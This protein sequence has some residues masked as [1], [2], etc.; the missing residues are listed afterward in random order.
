MSEGLMTMEEAA[1]Y[2][3]LTPRHVKELWARRRLTGVKMGRKVRFRRCDLD[4][5]AD[6]CLVRATR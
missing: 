1:A 5:Y 4:A 2:L 3:S 6:R